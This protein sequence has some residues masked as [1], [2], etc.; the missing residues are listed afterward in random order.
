MTEAGDQHYAERIA[1]LHIPDQAPGANPPLYEWIQVECRAGAFRVALD[2]AV[3]AQ[4]ESLQVDLALVEGVTETSIVVKIPGH[5]CDH[6]AP[7]P[8]PTEVLFELNPLTHAVQ[9]L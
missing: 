6:E 5:I 8:S 1:G 3:R 2:R 7:S 4:P 9:R